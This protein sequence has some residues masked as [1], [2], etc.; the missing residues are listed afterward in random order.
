MSAERKGS[1][2]GRTEEQVWIDDNTLGNEEQIGNIIASGED[3]LAVS[4][5]AENIIQETLVEDERCLK[6]TQTTPN[7][8]RCVSIA[9]LRSGNS[10]RMEY[11]PGG[12]TPFT[13]NCSTI[14]LLIL[15]IIVFI[16]VL[17]NIYI[18]SSLL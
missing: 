9:S 1:T 14:Y 11:V 7:H 17:F 10:R 4:N 5:V 15:L 6:V 16:I 2:D 13:W 12:S 8:G 18:F 3:I